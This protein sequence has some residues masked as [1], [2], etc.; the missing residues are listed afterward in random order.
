MESLNFN[1]LSGIIFYYNQITF[2]KNT[3]RSWLLLAAHNVET[4]SSHKKKK[5]LCQ[6]TDFRDR[7]PANYMF[8]DSRI[9]YIV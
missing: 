8:S 4:T 2:L 3:E 6:T 1:Y 7:C 5:G 9:V